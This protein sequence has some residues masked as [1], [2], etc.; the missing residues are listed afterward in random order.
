MMHDLLNSPLFTHPDFCVLRRV[1]MVYETK[2]NTDI[3]TFVATI[4]D[5]ETMG[6]NSE[7]DEIIELAA[8]SFSFSTNDGILAVTDTYNELNDPGKPIPAEITKVTKITDADVQGRS[9]DWN[10]VGLM[11]ERSH[12]IIC[13]NSGFDRNFLEQQTPEFISTLVKALPFG[14]TLRGVNWSELG[15][16]SAKLD[17]INW[18]LG[19]FYDGHRALNDCWATLN[20]LLAAPTA[21]DELKATVRKKEVLL[22]AANAPFDKKD[23][24]KLRGYRWSDGSARLPKGWWTVVAQEVV[25]EEYAWLDEA[26]YQRDGVGKTLPQLVITARTRYSHR[27]E[28]LL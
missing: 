19:Y 13:H 11:L 6:L 16:E 8:L 3:K 12:L 26:I 23:V 15:I 5:L 7:Q 17:Y 14:C 22:S 18:K 1:P 20:V 10:R 2:P 27:A 24:L 9:I 4:I 25:E 28:C 21:F